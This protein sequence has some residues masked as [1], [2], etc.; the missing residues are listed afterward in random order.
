MIRRA[1]VIALLLVTAAVLQT[2]LFPTV[3][4]L[5]FR[6]DLLLLLV[7]AFALRDGPLAGL[8]VGFAAGLLTDLLAAQTPIGLAVLIHTGIGYGIGVARPYLAPESITAP[9]LLTCFSS[10]VGTGAFG[11]LAVLLG[12]ERLP[13]SYLLQA[14]LVVGLYN[15]LLAPVVLALVRRLAERFPLSGHAATE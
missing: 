14:A 4:L 3:T 13:T 2:A 11:L 12:D 5:G 1:L 15:T 7:V 9:L 10:I 8:R 6:P